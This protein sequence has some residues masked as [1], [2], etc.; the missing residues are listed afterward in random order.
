MQEGPV[1]TEFKQFKTVTI[2][3]FSR[4]TKPFLLSNFLLQTV[5]NPNN[6]SSIFTEMLRILRS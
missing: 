1:K 6:V 3:R 5:E 4:T 2:V